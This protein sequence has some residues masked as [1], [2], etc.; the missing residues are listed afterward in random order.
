[1]KSPLYSI[2]RFCRSNHTFRN[3]END[4]TADWRENWEHRGFLRVWL[5]G[6]SFGKLRKSLRGWRHINRHEPTNFA[7]LHMRHRLI[8][9][10]ML[11]SS[12][13]FVKT[14]PTCIGHCDDFIIHIWYHS[15]GVCRTSR[16]EVGWGVRYTSG[17]CLRGCWLAVV[18]GLLRGG[19]KQSVH[20]WNRCGHS[21]RNGLL[22]R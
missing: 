4:S 9:H 14:L 8:F 1:M 20:R 7:G 6:D 10:G 22:H 2:S 16:V 3:H 17:R 12:C 19:C 11:G 5:H 15:C 18:V 13:G 21:G